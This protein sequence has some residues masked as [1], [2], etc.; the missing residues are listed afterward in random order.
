[1][2]PR[3]GNQPFTAGVQPNGAAYAYNST[4][5]D[6]FHSFINTEDEAAFDNTW[7]TPDFSSHQ[8]SGN[9]FDQ[10]GQSWQQNPYQ[11]SE[12][13]FLPMSQFNLD[14][15]YPAGDSGFQFPGFNQN[16][17][18]EFA[19]REPLPPPAYHNVSDYNH[20]PL[21]NDH[22]F[23]SSGPQELQQASQTIS[24]QAIESY[25]N[26]PQASFGDSRHTQSAS[27]FPT[28]T[29]SF[30]HGGIKTRD[31]I[32][33]LTHQDWRHLATR[34]VKSLDRPGWH[35][36]PT[37]QF[38]NTNNS[39]RFDGFIFVGNGSVAIHS[40]KATVPRYKRKRSRNETMRLLQIEKG[41]DPWHPDREPL[42]KKLKVAAKKQAGPRSAVP[43]V[44]SRGASTS[45]SS[46]SDS[47]DSSEYYSESEPEK[48]TDEPS[49]LPAMR[50][51]DPKKAV[52]YDLI[53]AVW[54]KRSSNLSGTVIRAALG[55]CWDIFK[56]IRDKWKSKA[57]SLQ[58]AIEKKDQANEKAFE[59]RVTE[60]RRLLESCIHLTLKH[61]HPSI[62]EKLGENP[63][64]LVVFY[65]FLVD[66]FKDSEY[67]GSFIASILQF[68]ARCTNINTSLLDKT[69]M[70]KLLIRIQKRGDDQ[71]KSLAHKILDNAK[72]AGG[73]TTS[74]PQA[75]G[76]ASKSPLVASKTSNGNDFK[77]E[78]QTDPKRHS[79]ETSKGINSATIAKATTSSGDSKTSAKAPLSDGAATKTKATSG[80][81]KPSGFFSSLKSASKRPGTSTKAE[82]SS[83][84]VAPEKKPDAPTLASKPAFSFAATM[85][86]LVKQKETAP[87]KTEESQK[88]ETTEEKRKRHRREQRRSLRVSFK[89]DDELVS[90]RTF[91]HDP[92]EELG[93]EDS[94]VR[95][96][97]DSK[98][99]G[100]MLK[101]HKD[102][103]LD[104]EE[105]YEP[106]E[107]IEVPPP[108][109]P[110]QPTDFSV[111]EDPE[112][113]RNYT[114]RAGRVDI[115]SPERD[116]QAEREKNTLMAIYT[117][118]SDIPPSPRE[119]A[120][121]YAG[122]RAAEQ[123]FGPPSGLT[124]DREA[125]YQARRNAQAVP[126]AAPAPDISAI[127]QI[128]NN[129]KQ[130][131]QSRP[132]PQDSSSN[133]LAAIFAKFSTNNQQAPQAQMAPQQQSTDTYSLQAILANMQ[134]PQQQNYQ[135]QPTYGTPQANPVPS[136][137]DILSQF[138]TQA[139]APQGPP[140][141]GYGY[142]ANANPYQMDNDRKRQ[143]END[144]EYGHGKGKKARGGKPFV[145]QPRLPC[146]F[147]Q[148]GKCRKGDE[149]TFL[150]ESS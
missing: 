144:D 63:V 38:A 74:T 29:G 93:H 31:E 116:I 25:P 137:Q 23:L 69:K 108:W 18:Q 114:S 142:N 44:Q 14:P 136:L 90:I 129:P 79:T 26:Y 65:Q 125:E 85:A 112:L 127:L 9:A 99:E 146:K 140:V 138:N 32:A 82:D 87:P 133:P 52:E 45:E 107:E 54:A 30:A 84:S 92:D 2:D 66:R 111:I 91:I 1:M 77:K 83:S 97:G 128:I 40:S 81:L 60:Q 35:I 43:L 56:G 71:G 22:H 105:E 33:P 55:G 20:G 39:K 64:L 15:R 75:N 100:Q 36:K 72:A 10:G 4:Q 109:V 58:Q 50:P 73:K 145:G 37:G 42:V 78:R 11:T 118:P 139:G 95:D 67:T 131:S 122:E 27:S 70:D 113:S 130:Q 115:I 86:D 88:P 41:N 132:Q 21:S 110:P 19:S 34:T 6:P 119:P 104:D 102:L 143:L 62:V 5:S 148:E 12:S 13:S 61:G 117:S 123:C 106:P 94:Q 76:T 80:A 3:Q 147:F 149:C 141:Q 124:K 121:P 46:E 126:S 150:H 98:G 47:D 17:V 24:P 120:D 59:R 57:N 51:A 8:Q 53:K 28:N 96:V 48:E 49:P 68:M 101:M 103:E 134:Q 89:G 135:P 7:Q 16:P